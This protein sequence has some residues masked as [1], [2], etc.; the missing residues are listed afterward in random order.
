MRINQRV[1]WGASALVLAGAVFGAGAAQASAPPGGNDFENPVVPIY[2]GY[3]VVQAGAPWDAIG[4]GDLTGVSGG[5]VKLV[6]RNLIRPAQG[7]Q[8]LDLNGTQPGRICG[9]YDGGAGGRDF[10]VSF[11][12]AGNAYGGPRL[13]TFNVVVDGQLTRSFSYD[14]AHTFPW[15][16]KWRS[17]SV[18]FQIPNGE[19]RALLHEHHA[20][21]IR[22][23]AGRPQ[24]RAIA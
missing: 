19:A 23:D 1:V 9:E 10:R 14:T 7:K 22:A 11:R 24:V 12:Y 6:R 18:D 8:S 5:N 21:G 4:G 16:P 13:K 3:L 2:K 20:W 15:L 17:G